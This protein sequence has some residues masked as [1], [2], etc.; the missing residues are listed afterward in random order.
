VSESPPWEPE[1]AERTVFRL[2]P[3]GQ[4]LVDTS[5]N[6]PSGAEAGRPDLSAAKPADPEVETSAIVNSPLLKAATPLLQLLGCL[7][8]TARPPDVQTLRDRVGREIGAFEKRCRKDGVSMELVR[9]AHYA[10]CAAIDD[11]VLHSPW[12]AASA[13]NARA[14]TASLYREIHNDDQIFDIFNRLRQEADKFLPVIELIYLCLSLGLLGRYRDPQYAPGDLDRLRDE[15]CNLITQ[16]R[17]CSDRHLSPRWKGVKDAYRIRVGKFPAW[18]PLLAAAVTVSTSSIWVSRDLNAESDRIYARVS[19]IPPLKM[20]EIVRATVARP[21]PQ[22]AHGTGSDIADRLREI[23]KGEPA[24]AS[25]V[26]TATVPVLRIS[27]QAIFQRGGASVRRS[28]VPTLERIGSVLQREPGSVQV[29]GHT[30]NAPTRTIQFPSNFQLSLAWA[31]AVRAVMLHTF[32][33]A[34]RISA[35]GRGDADPLES[36]TTAEGRTQ[37]CRIEI[38]VHPRQD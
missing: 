3:G 16:R 11:V 6:D 29:I 15:M 7:S 26:G 17:E 20:P 5:P 31:R 22:A 27:S 1:D 30:D 32:T 28:F 14:L 10:L 33:D 9:P 25:I 19:A 2:A 8:T 34:G 35:E 4:R 18:V 13:W 37:N 12:G 23:L 24:G 21:V 38:I 36:N